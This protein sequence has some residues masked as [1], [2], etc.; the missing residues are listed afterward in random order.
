[1]TSDD[2]YL[3][4]RSAGELRRLARTAALIEPETEDLFR[5]FGITAGMNVLEIGSGAGDVAMLVGRLVHPD[6]TVLGIER[7]ADSVALATQR[8]VGAANG[9]VRFEVGDLNSYLPTGTYDALVGRFVLPYLADPIGTLRRLAGS[10]RPGGVIAFME[11]DVRPIGST[12][13]APLFRTVADWIVRAY[14]KS[15]IDPSLGSSLGVAFRDAGLRWPYMTSFQKASCG[16]NGIIWWFAEMVRTLLPRIIQSGLATVEEVD[17]DSLG[18]RLEEEAAAMRL[19]VFSPRWV[20]AW[21]RQ[22]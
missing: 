6:G 4:G 13:E 19:T 1:M 18:T 5:R 12:P 22:P 10:V 14:E 3:L 20:S 7:S 17:I 8:A 11:F 9:A 15:G 2:T 16:P 21:V